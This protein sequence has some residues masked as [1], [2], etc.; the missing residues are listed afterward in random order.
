MHHIAIGTKNLTAMTEF[1]KKIPSLQF[2][3]YKTDD[4]GF[5]RS[6]WF[7]TQEGT[8]LMLEVR[9]TGNYDHL[10]LAIGVG[11]VVA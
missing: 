2:L 10:G 7:Q 9:Q 8:I 5:I 4:E 11:V 1:Y 3:E 6:A